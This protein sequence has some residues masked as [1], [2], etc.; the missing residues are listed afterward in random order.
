MTKLEVRVRRLL[1]IYPLDYRL[2]R[3]DEIVATVLDAADAGGG[4]YVGDLTS[5]VAHGIQM[6]LGLTADRFGGRVMDEAGLPGLYMAAA[7]S[8]FLFIWGEWLPVARTPYPIG[9]FGPFLTVG[10]V[11]YLVWITSA[12]LVGLR[13][14]WLR[15]VA[16]IS[17]AT[18]ALLWPLGKAFFASPNFWQLVLLIGLGLPATLAP[19]I[20]RSRRRLPTSVAAGIGTFAVMWWLGAVH[21]LNPPYFHGS[22]QFSFYTFGNYISARNLPWL[23][24]VVLCALVV[25][26]ICRQSVRAGALVVLTAPLLALAAGSLRGADAAKVVHRGFFVTAGI[27]F[28]VIPAISLVV[29]WAVD[30]RRKGERRV[31]SA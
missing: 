19:T 2:Q 10:P 13:P 28:L 20:V 9:R 16:V 29:A 22:V 31:D 15:P 23:A 11:I 3:G 17:V 6:R 26:V 30:L 12:L 14:Q 18:T 27:S 25:L 4:T 21:Y 8:I 1:R 24:G 5:L 7:V